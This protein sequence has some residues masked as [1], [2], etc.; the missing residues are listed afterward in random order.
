MACEMLDRCARLMEIDPRYT[1]RR[2][3]SL[4]VQRGTQVTQGSADGLRRA[5]RHERGGGNE[6]ATEGDV[7][8]LLSMVPAKAL[9]FLAAAGGDAV[10]RE[11]L[12]L[13]VCSP[14]AGRDLVARRP[15][16]RPWLDVA[17][18]TSWPVHVAALSWPGAASVAAQATWC[19]S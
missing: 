2:R 10:V 3:G 13:G 19:I 4:I 5:V 16:R 11:G 15:Q 6:R 7:G 8:E 14:D 18:S 12:Q 1:D 9:G 17:R